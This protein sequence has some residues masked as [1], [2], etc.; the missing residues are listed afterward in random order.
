MELR[1]K[2]PFYRST[3]TVNLM[4]RTPPKGDTEKIL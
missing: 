2:L 4:V 1:N 3:F